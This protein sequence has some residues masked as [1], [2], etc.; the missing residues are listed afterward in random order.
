MCVSRTFQGMF[1]S[2]QRNIDALIYAAP[3]DFIDVIYPDRHPRTLVCGFASSVA[4]G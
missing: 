2:S 3:M 4:E 1:V